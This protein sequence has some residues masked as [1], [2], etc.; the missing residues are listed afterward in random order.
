MTLQSP[1]KTQWDWALT[2]VGLAVLTGALSLTSAAIAQDRPVF[3]AS[4]ELAVVYAVVL[5]DDRAVTDLRVEDFRISEDGSERP[6]SVFIPPE[7]A[8]R[9]LIVAVDASGSMNGWPAK[10]AVN[11]LLD[12]LHAGSC[13]LLLPFRETVLEGIWGH[14]DDPELRGMLADLEFTGEEAIFDALI[15]ASARLRERALE[16]SAD[17][18][19]DALDLPGLAELMRLRRL[20]RDAGWEQ[21]PMPRGD[22]SV[23]RNPW[24]PVAGSEVRRSI[25]V[26]TDGADHKSRS[27][28][29]DVLLFTW[30]TGV[31]V[32]ILAAEPRPSSGGFGVMGR[33]NPFGSL[34]ALERLTE[35]TGGFTFRAVQD[36]PENQNVY[37]DLQRLIGGLNGHYILG[38]VPARSGTAQLLPDRREIEVEVLRAG[39]EV[40]A[41]SHVVRGRPQTENAALEI[42]LRGFREIAGGR[43]EAA[44]DTFAAAV[45]TAP[46]MG[47]THYGSGI[48]LSQAGRS[49]EALE[50]FREATKWAPW[51]PDLDARQ[52][53][54]LI[55]TG[56]VDGAWT[57][58]LNAHAAG[59][60]AHP[61]VE[62]LQ[63]LAPRDVDLAQLMPPP[64]VSLQAGGTADPLIQASVVPRLLGAV[65]TAVL[66]SPSMVVASGGAAADLSL[67][68][69]LDDVRQHV[70][71]ISVRGWLVLRDADGDKLES[72]RLELKDARSEETTRAA[73]SRAMELIEAAVRAYSAVRDER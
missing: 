28:I 36:Y 11:L 8:P 54:L 57:H 37:R 52:A 13:V 58:A 59:S 14:P 2:L 61:I 12:S 39:H 46:E 72:V 53:E 51:L 70:R 15:V 24:L 9:E 60:D 10:E 63:R 71:Q 67:Y 47:L 43:V 3:R 4:S 42:A 31:P 21:T 33:P 30:G 29:E 35:F 69:D 34:R 5:A 22:C 44:V 50:A 40:L 27:D 56:D 26:V 25:A 17:P 64:R 73:V 68:L 20:P 7:W 48:A 32:F 49:T 1:R 38:Y 18:A 45:T 62:R 19:P 55:A 6:I 65:G 41:Q 66:R 16:S 23:A